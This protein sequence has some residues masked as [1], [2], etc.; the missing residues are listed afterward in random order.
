MNIKYLYDS[1]GHY[2][3]IKKTHLIH[4]NWMCQCGQ[5]YLDRTVRCKRCRLL[6]KKVD[7]RETKMVFIHKLLHRR[8]EPKPPMFK[9]AQSYTRFKM[10]CRNNTHLSVESIISAHYIQHIDQTEC[11]DYVGPICP[12][13]KK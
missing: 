8:G 5:F 4:D 11:L 12:C 2:F 1:F 10:N 7:L 9:T 6:R 3:N 13:I